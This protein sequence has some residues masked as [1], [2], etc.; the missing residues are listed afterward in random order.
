MYCVKVEIGNPCCTLIAASIIIPI[1]TKFYTESPGQLYNCTR[2]CS[3][4]YSG[5]VT[6]GDLVA[7][8]PQP[9]SLAQIM[10]SLPWDPSVLDY[11]KG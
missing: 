8:H 4:E 5:K 2:P 3:Y 9:E 6:E 1:I 7:E 11:L 10:P